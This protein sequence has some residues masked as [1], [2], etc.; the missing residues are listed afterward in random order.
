MRG[1]TRRL[2]LTNTKILPNLKSTRASICHHRIEGP[3]PEAQEELALLVI[4]LQL[5]PCSSLYSST[6]RSAGAEDHSQPCALGSLQIGP[7]L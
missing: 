5:Q 6:L 3:F 1:D 7:G 4:R 2:A